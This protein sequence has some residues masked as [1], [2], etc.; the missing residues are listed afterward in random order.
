VR[1]AAFTPL[2]LL[3]A[4]AVAFASAALGVSSPLAFDDHPGQL[5]RAWHVVQHG[6][7]PWA[8]NPGW[9]AGYPEL[10]FYP[11]G[12]AYATA[13]LHRASLGFLSVPAA[14]HA[15]LWV[16]YVAPGVTAY[17]LLRRVT[18][19]G[20]S[21]LPGAFVALTL[22]A[23]VASGVEGGVRWGMVAARLG[24]ALLPL[25]PL[26]LTR[27]VD[28]DGPL[29]PVL[30]PLVAAIGIIHP[31]H[32]PAAIALVIAAALATGS[33]R[34]TRVGAAALALG[35]A[36]A[37]AAF[38]AVPLLLRLAHTRALAWGTLGGGPAAALLR[39]L[40]L[41]LIALALL[42]AGAGRVARR[43]RGV[44]AAGD[45]Q[46]VDWTTATPAAT[47]AL[48][49][50]ARLL[51]SA[52]WVLAVVVAADALVAEPL[53]ARWLPADRVADGAWMALV[54][55]AGVG[56]GRLV[57]RL[58]ATRLPRAGIALAMC[59]LLAL[60]AQPGHTLTLWPRPGEW[61]TQ[62]SVEAGFRLPAT[63]A[64]LEAG[65]EGRVLIAR[66]GLPLVHGTAWYR[67]H[68]H[69]TALTPLRAGRPIIHGTFTHPSPVAAFL[70]RGD[71]GR[72]AITE[73]AE[74]HDGVAL[75]GRAFADLPAAVFNDIA[76]RL[77]ISS[78]LVLDEDLVA[79]DAMAGN[80]AFAPRPSPP[81]FAL[82]ARSTPVP[83]PR[84]VA[85][86]H[87]RVSP[88][89][90]PGDWVSARLAY[91]PLWRAEQGGRPLSVREG[92]QGE[93]EVR[94]AAADQPVELTY[95]AGG[96]ERAGLAIS[97]AAAVVW[98][99][100]VARTRRRAYTSGS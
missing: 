74:R 60:F 1:V 55:A 59:G 43:R 49:R 5:Y 27:W 69:I 19:N 82:Y 79:R 56:A 100:W 64:A 29:P 10:Q 36:A 39:P 23:G 51:A 80:G 47:A 94:L 68:T 11:P 98:L 50:T 78:V 14:Y 77:G 86:G 99:A 18:G 17:A 95:R 42:A 81:P 85:P 75:F 45:R 24:W 53:G 16:A 6:V 26:A 76:D 63:W 84:Q 33:R 57:E 8:W 88:G 62:A 46:G 2:V 31:A 89:G 25:V 71:A 87:W 61:P 20:W 13:L 37:L 48:P 65:P 3:L 32:L 83:I 41:A 35:L 44:P 93:L 22:S 73:L 58:S 40:P 9:W 52:P 91:Y 28:D 72:G 38:W 96:P 67:P 66:S 97:G 92:A 15:L 12:F 30:A 7:A 70:Y 21:A 90:S 4:G 54:L 34:S